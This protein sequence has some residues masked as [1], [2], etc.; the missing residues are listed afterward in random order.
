[1]LVIVKEIENVGEESD[2]GWYLPSLDRYDMNI[3]RAAYEECVP[4][5]DKKWRPSPR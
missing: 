2:K 1:M 4:P 5:Y 3:S